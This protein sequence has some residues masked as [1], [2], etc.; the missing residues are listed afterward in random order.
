MND[1]LP[2]LGPSAPP[3]TERP[4]GRLVRVQ[5]D[6]VGVSDTFTYEVPS[7]WEGDGRADQIAIGGL[8]RIDFSG[9]RI[10]GWITEVNVADDNSVDAIRPLK[11]WSSIGPSSEVMDLGRWAAWRWA[12][13]PVH[14]LRAASPTRMVRERRASLPRRQPETPVGFERALSGGVTL[15]RTLPTED[16]SHVVHAAT[17]LG[18]TLV[19][20]PTLRHRD[21]VIRAMRA[22]G[23]NVHA[24]PDAWEM[25]IR[26]HHLVGT[27]TAALATIPNLAAIIVLDEHDGAL[28]EERTPGWNARDL[29]IE[30]GR[31]LD[32]PVVL[33][34]ATPSLEGL[35]A[36][37]RI[38]APNRATERKGW[39]RVD[40]VDM[41]TTD[42]PGL[43]SERIVEPVRTA[44]T[45]ACVLNRKGRARMLVCRRCDALATCELCSGTVVEGDDGNLVCPADGTTRPAVCGECSFTSFK[46]LRLGISSLERDLRV[47]AGRSVTEVSADT[48]APVPTSGLLLGTAALLQRLERADVVIFLDFDQELR[49]PRV[50]AAEEAF[51][52]IGQAA[53]LTGRRDDGGRLIIQ[54][55][56]PDDLVIRAAELGEPGD[57]ARHLRN[58]RTVFSQPP[59]GAWALVSGAGAAEWAPAVGEQPGV[60][61]ARKADEWRLSAPDHHVLLDAIASVPRPEDRLRVVVDP[62]DA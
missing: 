13:S 3:R 31:R 6:I 33:A 57:V 53:R 38:L 36:A 50:R 60:T 59:Y 27:R 22:E 34:S 19:I 28:K 7:S 20:A 62:I 54:T 37:D 56:R 30:R 10:R 58:V 25:G 48:T 4:T 43:L 42:R 46:F 45:V 8:V 16:V 23:A 49:R 55:Y 47:L 32:I 26:G 41:R 5:P 29:A 12:G 9:R 24:H 51:A 1:P 35:E 44:E 40:V 14:F 61:V 39:P 21:R 52:M 2:G 17:R 11:K 15:L 18:T